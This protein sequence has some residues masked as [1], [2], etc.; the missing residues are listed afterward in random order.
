MRN[1][2]YLFLIPMAMFLSAACDNSAAGGEKAEQTIVF[3]GTAPKVKTILASDDTTMYWSKYD[4]LV[5]YLYEG[6]ECKAYDICKFDFTSVSLKSALFYPAEKKNLSQWSEVITDKSAS[7]F[8]AVSP[9]PAEIPVPEGYQ[10]NMRVAAEQT[11]EYGPFQISVASGASFGPVVYLPFSP[12]TAMFSLRCHLTSDSP[13]TSTK[14]YKMD[15]KFKGAIVAGD[16]ILDMSTGSLIPVDSDQEE[17]DMTL[18]FSEPVVVSKVLSDG[19]PSHFN[20]YLRC[21][22]IP[23]QTVTEVL[24]TVYDKEGNAFQS[25]SPIIPSASGFAGGSDSKYDCTF[26]VDKVVL[27]DSVESEGEEGFAPDWEVEL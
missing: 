4:N 1:I 25:T 17:S 19:K 14:I 15:L 26:Y 10:V 23:T 7:L 8:Y 27:N 2:I 12:A 21:S 9:V 6:N 13:C 5:A 20:R 18:V 16:C 22:L 24:V 3:S 11:G